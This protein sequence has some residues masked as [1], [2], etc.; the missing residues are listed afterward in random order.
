MGKQESVSAQVAASPSAVFSMVTDVSRLP[1]WNEAITDVVEAPEHLEAGS[2]WKVRLHALGQ[3]WVS[4][5][6][7]SVID[8]VTGRFAYRSQSDDG[9]R[10][11]TATRMAPSSLSPP[12]STPSRSGGS[13]SSSGSVAPRSARKCERRL[14]PWTASFTPDV[15]PAHQS[16]R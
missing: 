10:R 12:T 11:S 1:E 3:T 6:Q 15:A 8:S 2:V 7:V 13:T 9:N 4:K 14:P 16:G 5:S